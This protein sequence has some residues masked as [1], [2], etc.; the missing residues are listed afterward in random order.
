MRKL[1]LAIVIC[2]LPVLAWSHPGKTDAVGG[3][4]CY[5]DCEKWELLFGEYHLHDKDGRPIRVAKKAKKKKERPVVEEPLVDPLS[6][7]QVV[8]PKLVQAAALPLSARSD[9]PE[10]GLSVSPW[11][12]L[13]LALLLLLLLIRRRGREGY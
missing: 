5:K 6:A 1:F 9:P 8:P 3:H 4:K 11:I 10:E 7:E 12:L 2:A 13:L